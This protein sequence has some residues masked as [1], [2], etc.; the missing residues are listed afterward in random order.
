MGYSQEYQTE[1]EQA[2]DRNAL[3]GLGVPPLVALLMIVGGGGAVTK[4][5]IDSRLGKWLIANNDGKLFFHIFYGAGVANLPETRSPLLDVIPASSSGLHY[6]MPFNYAVG[7]SAA[8]Q[9]PMW[10]ISAFSKNS[11][12]AWK[13]LWWTGKQDEVWDLYMEKLQDW[14]TVKLPPFPKPNYWG[15]SEKSVIVDRTQAKYLWD[16][17]GKVASTAA[18]VWEGV[19]RPKYPDVKEPPFFIMTPTK[20]AK[21]MMDVHR[22][23]KLKKAIG[24]FATGSSNVLWWAGG[25]A[26]AGLGAYGGYRGIKHY[27]KK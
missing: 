1:N 24:R 16:N 12:A 6:F 25:L 15:I 23:I 22:L 18:K 9:Q 26:V 21:T 4:T 3:A 10:L 8:N 20:D 27:I 7:W 13:R 17:S 11:N 5:I 14:S 19:I 2:L